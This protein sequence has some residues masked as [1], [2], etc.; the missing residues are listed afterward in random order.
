MTATIPP[1]AE[2]AGNPRALAAWNGLATRLQ[3]DG[4]YTVTNLEQ[5]QR[6]FLQ[7]IAA[8]LGPALAGETPP[9]Q[10]NE[11]LLNDAGRRTALF[12]IMFNQY[13]NNPDRWAPQTTQSGGNMPQPIIPGTYR[14]DL[15]P[16]AQAAD[17]RQMVERL[18]AAGFD[19][20]DTAS[21]L[22]AYVRS[23][24]PTRTD[25]DLQTLDQ[26]A[27][28]AAFWAAH[29]HAS[30]GNQVGQPTRVLKDA[31]GQPLPTTPQNLLPGTM[32]QVRGPQPR[33]RVRPGRGPG[34][35]GPGQRGPG[36]RGP[37]RGQQDRGEGDEEDDDGPM[38]GR[39]RRQLQSWAQRHLERDLPRDPERRAELATQLRTR[40]ERSGVDLTE[41]D[42]MTPADRRAALLEAGLN[43][44]QIGRAETLLRESRGGPDSGVPHS[45]YRGMPGWAQRAFDHTH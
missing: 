7:S 27:L 45:P 34:Q 40:L 20:T 43:R 44:G 23:Q 37:G 28:E 16:T 14:T 33:Q 19:I 2:V 36:Q 1:P 39:P 3:R 9:I 4:G 26:T 42:S 21:A 15:S 17:W 11:A 35:R 29:S 24:D 30:A 12:N 8:R 25:E 31:N 38:A 6:A 10:L 22:R 13:F 41:L 5:F 32:A 18:R